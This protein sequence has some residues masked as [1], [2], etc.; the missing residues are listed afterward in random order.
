MSGIFLFFIFNLIYLFALF[1]A[2]ILALPLYYYP[3]V[4]VHFINPFVVVVVSGL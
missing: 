2:I 4:V 3:V 1:F